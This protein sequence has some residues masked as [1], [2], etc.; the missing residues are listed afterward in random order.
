MGGVTGRANGANAALNGDLYNRQL[1][2]DETNWIRDNAEK[3][4]SQ[5][6]GGCMPSPEQVEDAKARLGQQASKDVDFIWKSIL[7]AGDDE[8]AREFLANSG[9]TYTNE[10][11]K[12]QAMFTTERG[13]FFAPAQNMQDV[14]S[15]D[16]G[17]RIDV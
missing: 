10:V 5:Q 17:P 15:P 12:P 2:P 1:H 6:R 16:E 7:P 13:Q 9:A 8:A 14:D 3:F 4:A 11:G